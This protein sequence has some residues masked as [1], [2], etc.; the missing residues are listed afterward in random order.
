[1]KLVRDSVFGRLPGLARHRR[2]AALAV[3]AAALWLAAA[4]ASALAAWPTDGGGSGPVVEV[5]SLADDGAGSL[6]AAI[7]AKGPR[8]IVFKVA[9]DILLKKPLVVRNPEV[10][11]AGETAPSPGITIMGDKI[12]LRTHDVILRHLRVHVGEVGSSDPS[13]RDGISIEGHD[14]DKEPVG[15]ILVEN[16]SVLWAI[17]ENL[18]MWGANVH[19]VAIRRSIVAEALLDSIHPKGEHAMGLMVGPG[20]K[21]VLLQQNLIAHNAWRNPVVHGGASA[22]VMNNL[23]YNP[24]YAA[25]HFYPRKDMGPTLVSAI[26]NVAVA[27]PD[28][29]AFLPAFAKGINPDSRIF[30]QSNGSRRTKA[31]DP[32]ER[33]PEEAGGASLVVAEPPITIPEAQAIPVQAVEDTVLKDAGARPWDRDAADRRLVEEVRGRTGTLRNRPDDPRLVAPRGA[34]AAPA[35]GN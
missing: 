15:R 7:G 12:R 19:D 28:T 32:S 25:L 6:R 34:E 14:G 8:T 16:C 1:M 22:V 33:L 2:R 23:I 13:N 24:R 5:T 27:G 11:V 4:P 18:S 9:G 31:F 20:A 29:R 10:T 35:Q 30:Y 21:N 3:L 26:G 17:D